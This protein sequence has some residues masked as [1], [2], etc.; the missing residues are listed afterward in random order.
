MVKG[1]HCYKFCSIAAPSPPRNLMGA[2]DPDTPTTYSF[3]WS[4]PEDVNGGVVM[5]LLACV[6]P[7]AGLGGGAP[8]VSMKF[9]PS[10]TSGTLS[11]LS[12]NVRYQCTVQARNMAAISRPSNTV[13]FTI[14]ETGLWVCAD[15]SVHV[16]K[17]GVPIQ[18]CYPSGDKGCP[19][20][21]GV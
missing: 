12:F 13:V 11:G 14:S 2:A 5:Y 17:D 6:L 18:L 21:S 16:Y 4:P 3:T 10:S 7:D 19:C 15:W 1:L 8:E 9:D 20:P